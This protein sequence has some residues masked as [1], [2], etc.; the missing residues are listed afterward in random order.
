[1]RLRFANVALLS[2][3]S[4]SALSPP[5]LLF[6]NLKEQKMALIQARVSQ[7]VKDRFR[8]LA[9]ES[10]KDESKFLREM[11]EIVLNAEKTPSEAVPFQRVKP[12][13]EK[14][15]KRKVCARV[16]LFIREALD[17]AAKEKGLAP[18][19]YLAG[20]IQSNLTEYPVFNSEEVEA[21]THSNRELAS[22]GRNLNQIARALN[23]SFYE[24]DR[25]KVELIKELTDS[26]NSNQQQIKKLVR[27]SNQAWGAFN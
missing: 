19:R 6:L 12:D 2:Y 26:I 14:I 8:S 18:T 15:E 25:I 11:I 4:S 1:M 10:S 7:A 22:I 20:L 24:T 27:A 21:L 16:P 17:H 23:E 3:N 9:K 5:P 13:P